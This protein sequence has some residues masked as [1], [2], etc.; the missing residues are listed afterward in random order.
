MPFPLLGER[1]REK[2]MF[3]RQRISAWKKRGQNLTH[4]T[5]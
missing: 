2:E 4:S 3:A 1:A 5:P